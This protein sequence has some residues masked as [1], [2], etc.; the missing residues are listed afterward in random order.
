[1]YFHFPV[2]SQSRLR[3]RTAQW[4]SNTI[5]P[6]FWTACFWWAYFYLI[7]P[8]LWLVNLRIKSICFGGNISRKASSFDKSAP[9]AIPEDIL[10]PK[11]SLTYHCQNGGLLTLA[12]K[13]SVWY[14]H[15]V[16]WH[17]VVNQCSSLSPSLFTGDAGASIGAL[18]VY[19]GIGRILSISVVYVIYITVLS[20][21]FYVFPIESISRIIFSISLSDTDESDD[22]KLFS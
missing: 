5:I 3:L 2:L 21:V 12:S 20:T 14:P 4:V 22:R 9:A 1:M 11:M 18:I 10:L 15:F 6:K 17:S 7:I 13:N 19:V 8:T 16:P